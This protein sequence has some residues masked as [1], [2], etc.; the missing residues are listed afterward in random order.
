MLRHS[1][2]AS[3]RKAQHEHVIPEPRAVLGIPRLA[4]NGGLQY[5]ELQVHLAEEMPRGA[6]RSP[7]RPARAS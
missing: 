6:R 3:V 1:T 5:L 4:H 7:R 2:H